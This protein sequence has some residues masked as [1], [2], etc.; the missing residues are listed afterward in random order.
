MNAA[1]DQAERLLGHEDLIVSK[2]DTRG[3]LTYVNQT[4]V[5]VSG[6]SE[7]E[8]LGKP[9]NII[10]HPDM[11]RGVFKLLWDTI[12]EGGEVFAYVVN[13]AKDGSRYW[14]LAHVTPTFGGYGS[15]A[16]YHSSRRAPAPSAIA[17]IEAVYARMRAEEA[18]HTK[19]REAAEASLALLTSV[20]DAEGLTYEQ[21]VWDLINTTEVDLGLAE[22][23]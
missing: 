13:R 17:R 5:E 11:P 19:V 10:R 9:H 15:I 14:V 7:A 3:I 23:G 4:F 8:L 2:T 16:G 22:V 20:L 21:F 6:Y 1:P 12:A 18:R